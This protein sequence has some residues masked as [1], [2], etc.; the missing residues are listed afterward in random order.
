ML[1]FRNMHIKLATESC[2][3]FFE[4]RYSSKEKLLKDIKFETSF[5]TLSYRDKKITIPFACN[6]ERK[7]PNSMH[8]R[9]NN[10]DILKI[11]SSE[12]GFQKL[13]LDLEVN[14]AGSKLPF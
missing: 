8:L 14:K 11:F 2:Y 9:E 13:S 5:M 12:I 4:E 6:Y 7:N 10:P 3:E 1:F